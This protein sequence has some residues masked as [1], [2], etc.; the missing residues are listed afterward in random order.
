MKFNR[1]ANNSVIYSAEGSS[2]STVGGGIVHIQEII[3][4]FAKRNFQVTCVIRQSK[5][6]SVDTHSIDCLIARLP[7][8]VFPYS[9]FVYLISLFV[10]A[11]QIVKVRPRFLYQRDTG[12][13]VGIILGKLFRIPTVLE[14]NGNILQDDPFLNRF[15][16]AFL[17]L[18][19]LLSYSSADIVTTPSRNLIPLIV[20]LGAK[21]EKVFVIPNGV[22]SKLFHPMNREICRKKL[23]FDI[24]AYYL[25]F[26]GTLLPW[27]GVDGALKA[28][29][30][31][32]ADN[33][34]I[35]AKLVIVGDGPVREN[36][37]R[38]VRDLKINEKVTLVG[39]IPYNTVPL[40]INASDV[41]LAP[42]TFWRNNSIGVSPLK[43]CEYLSCGKPV[44]AS[45]VR[46]VPEIV[47]KLDAGIIVKPDNIIDLKHA[48]SQAFRKLQYWQNR[49][50]ALH[51]K[52][53]KNY[54]WDRRTDDILH[55]VKTLVHVNAF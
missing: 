20:F 30:G 39:R 37:C 31:F 7:D 46:G 2:L 5:N 54:S 45:A 29:Y 40:Y 33:P 49:S 28:F 38:L 36:L 55:I 14:I 13:N 21:Q 1:N 50:T 6:R 42:F 26:V 8:W 35:N 10:L 53:S 47:E 43:L 51:Y 27:Q 17:R 32:L 4:G 41:C 11:L 44:I 19:L 25:C 18:L 9:F 16:K 52:V 3:N 24:N 12:V 23:G 48:Y 34:E 15:P 22:N